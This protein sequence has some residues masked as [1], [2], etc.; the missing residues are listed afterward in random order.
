L[1]EQKQEKFL[2]IAAALLED[3]LWVAFP[4]FS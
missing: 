1:P 2:Q 4:S 3:E